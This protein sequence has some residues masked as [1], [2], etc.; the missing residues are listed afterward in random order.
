MKFLSWLFIVILCA[1]ALPSLALETL[2]T[3]RDRGFVLLKP[4]LQEHEAKGVNRTTS[5]RGGS[6]REVSVFT[7]PKVY[8][9]RK[10]QKGKGAYGGATINHNP[11]PSAK[12]AASVPKRSLFFI[13]STTILLPLTKNKIQQPP[14]PKLRIISQEMK[15]LSWLFIVILCAQALPSLALET[16]STTRDR[17]FVLLKPRLQEHEVK[18]VNRTTSLRGESDTEVSV[19]MQPK[20]YARKAQKGKGPTGGANID[21]NPRPSAKSAASVPKRSLFFTLSKTILYAGFSWILLF[22][23]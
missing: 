7:Q 9:A 19:F 17:G 11:R 13:L 4:H 6:D 21:R 1:Q 18:G 23:F 3:T 12:S 5:L 10:A 2:S 8:Y 20:V 16:L 14:S 15:F 22:P